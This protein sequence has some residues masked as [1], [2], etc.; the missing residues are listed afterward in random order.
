MDLSMSIASASMT[1]SQARLQQA[2]SLS[3][4]KKTMDGQEASMETL[5]RGLEAAVP[6][7][8]EHILDVKV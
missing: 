5:L 3:M 7:P 1:M 2:A 6:P 4:L 8:S